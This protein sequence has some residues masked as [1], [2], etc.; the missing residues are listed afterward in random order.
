MQ[1]S[2]FVR[3]VLAG[4]FAALSE[5]VAGCFGYEVFEYGWVRGLE[6]AQ[7]WDG[8]RLPR[9]SDAYVAVG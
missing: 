9:S 1:S 2:A 3:V 4:M 6:L 7:G 5:P 8:M